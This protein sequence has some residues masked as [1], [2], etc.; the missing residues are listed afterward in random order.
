MSL[1]IR[2]SV[3][4]VGARPDATPAPAPSRL[5]LPIAYIN[6][7]EDAARR[8]ALV[9]AFDAIGVHP[10][11]QSGVR[12]TRLSAPEQAAHYSTELNAKSYFRPLVDGEKGCYASHLACWQGLLDSAAAALVVLEDDVL[13]EPGFVAVINA[14][15]ALPPGWDMVKLIGRGHER[16]RERWPLAAGFE[17]VRFRR[18]P[19]LTAGY[20]V[21]RRGAHKLLATRRPY[22]RPID[23]DLRQWWENALVMRGVM[24][25]AIGLAPIEASSSIGA[26]A[27]RTGL[28]QR[29][30]KFVFKLRYTLANQRANRP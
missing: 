27:G 28:E 3:E 11:R 19:S 7:D 5:A 1:P 25:A 2:M 8:D 13:P 18:V 24:P 30:R 9:A 21:S 15:A 6:L 12:W 10:Q 4:I 17:L 16:P 26:R 20:V 14:I 29:W 23:V 22:A